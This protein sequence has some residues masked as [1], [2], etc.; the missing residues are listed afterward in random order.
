MKWL[1]ITK[2][3]SRLLLGGMV[4][5]M[6]MATVPAIATAPMHPQLVLAKLNGQP[7]HVL[8]LT[9]NQDRILV[10]C[11]PGQQPSIVVKD[12]VGGTK[13]G[14]LSCGN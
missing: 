9:R 10:R 13:E 1:E 12:K 14:T 4:A 11:Y 8:Y 6:V 7:I 5:V 3:F 2:H